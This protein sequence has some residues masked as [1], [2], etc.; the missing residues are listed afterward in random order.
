MERSVLRAYAAALTGLALA[1]VW[2][3][4][5]GRP[6]PGGDPPAPVAAAPAVASDGLDAT[7]RTRAL[8]RA[9]RDAAAA[10][11]A[12]AERRAAVAVPEPV[13]AFTQAPPVVATRS[14]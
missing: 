13:V 12:D 9:Y 2:L 11:A 3:G 1:G 4:V 14:S 7:A 10:V 5:A 8:A 6:L